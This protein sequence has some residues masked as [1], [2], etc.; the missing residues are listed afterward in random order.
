VVEQR[1]VPYDPTVE[2]AVALERGLPLWTPDP[3]ALR[4]A[5]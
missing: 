3:P 4:T 2:E 5:P 1:R